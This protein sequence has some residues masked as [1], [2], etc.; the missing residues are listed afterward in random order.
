MTTGAEPHEA[1][2]GALTFRGSADRPAF[3]DLLASIDAGRVKSVVFAVPAGTA[4][5]LPLYEL[6]AAD[7]GAGRF[8]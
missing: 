8:E 7:R 4:W 5:P 1:V 3:E 6:A 2:P